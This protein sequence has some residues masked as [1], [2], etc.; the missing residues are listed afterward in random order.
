MS[1]I[2]H[3]KAV[4]DALEAPQQLQDKIDRHPVV[5]ALLD[6]ANGAAGLVNQRDQLLF[7]NRLQ[8]QR[9]SEIEGEFATFRANTVVEIGDL[10]EQIDSLTAQRDFFRKEADSLREAMQSMQRTGERALA[11]SAN[12]YTERSRQR[13]MAGTEARDDG[14]PIPTF[15]RGSPPRGNVT[16]LKVGKP[17]RA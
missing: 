5:Q 4:A 7:E 1:E 9:I 16:P 15:L 10:K 17:V 12:G 3:L 8:S 2:S 11:V 6:V 14:E 13:R